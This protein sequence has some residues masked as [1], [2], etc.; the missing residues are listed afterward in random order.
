MRGLLLRSYMARF[1]KIPVEVEAITF[2][3]L[4]KFGLDQG[5]PSVRGMPLRLHYN[6]HK[7]EY[8]ND[9]CYLIPTKEGVMK[10]ERGAML[11]TGVEGEIYPCA[12][13]I[14]AATYEKV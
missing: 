8:E 1:R 2:G 5:V 12:G 14:F 13:T 6:G 7:I 9:N 11:I 3:E 10:L 4:V